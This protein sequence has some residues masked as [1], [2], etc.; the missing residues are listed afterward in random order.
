MHAVLKEGEESLFI[1]PL[2]PTR[3]ER[4]KP[5]KEGCE[6]VLV[7][8]QS[9][10]DKYESLGT[11][12]KRTCDRM[13][14]GNE[15][16]AEIRARLTSNIS[17]LTAFISTSQVSVEA[18]LDKFIE[19]YRQGKKETSVVSLQTVDSLSTNDRAVWRTIRKKLEEIGISV[20]AFDTNRN[21]IFDWFIHAVEAGAFEEQ[22]A[23]SIE[24]EGNYSDEQES[25]SNEEHDSDD[26]GR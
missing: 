14:W 16:V 22:N 7:D 10:V 15:D 3:A 2:P 24:D 5:I 23:Y 6:K 19:E 11:Q 1:H 9:L 13:R 18:K 17:L 4:L 12:S 26:A 25:K 21:F 20:A 8:L